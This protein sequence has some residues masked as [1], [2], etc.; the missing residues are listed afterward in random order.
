[1]FIV[2][3]LIDQHL[4]VSALVLSGPLAHRRYNIHL[5]ALSTLSAN[6]M[7]STWWYYTIVLYLFSVCGGWMLS[8][9][10]KQLNNLS[11]CLSV[12]PYVR[13]SVSL[14]VCASVRLSVCTCALSH[15]PFLYSCVCLSTPHSSLDSLSTCVCVCVCVC[16]RARAR[17]YVCLSHCVPSHFQYMPTHTCL[18]VCI[19]LCLFTCLCSLVFVCVCV[20]VKNLFNV[21]KKT[22]RYCILSLLT[23]R[24][25]MASNDDMYT[26][27]WWLGKYNGCLRHRSLVHDL[28]TVCIPYVCTCCSLLTL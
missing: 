5:S 26:E 6:W 4:L 14:S 19:Y 22:S 11:V 9:L 17:L 8:W 7:S 18:S 25:L 24:I 21:I 12:C 13:P 2:Y 27:V 20:C 10:G 16:T 3:V 23:C 1:M 15:F 28:S